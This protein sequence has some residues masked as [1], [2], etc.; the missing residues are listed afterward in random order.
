MDMPGEEASG[1]HDRVLGLIGDLMPHQYPTVDVPGTTFHLVG[2]PV[3]VPTVAAMNTLLPTW[4]DP[5]IPLGPFAEDAAETEVVRPRHVQ[6][7]PGYLAAMLVHRR[8]VTAKIAYQEMQGALQAR[9]E[10]IACRDVLT[11]LRAAATARGGGGAQTGV[12]IV[13]HPFTPLHLPAEVYQFVVN[14]L[15]GDLPALAAPDALTGEVT[16]TLAG[17]LRVLT[18]TRTRS[19]GGDRGTREAKTVQEAYKETF[20]ILLRYGNVAE[21]ADVAPIWQRLA[22]ASKKSEYH[23]ILSQELQCVCIARGL[24]TD[25]YVPVVTTSLKQMII[26][27]QF[28]GNGIDDLRSGCLP[29]Q[30]SYAGSANH[31]RAPC[32]SRGQ[33]QRSASSR[34]AQRELGRSLNHR[35]P[36]TDHQVSPQHDGGMHHGGPLLRIMPDTLLRR[37]GA[38]QPVCRSHVAARLLTPECHSIYHGAVH[39]SR[40]PPRH[41]KRLL[42][43]YLAER[44]GGR[45]RIPTHGRNKSPRSR[46]WPE[47]N[48]RSIEP[49]SWIS[50]EGH[51]PI[52]AS[53]SHSLKATWTHRHQQRDVA[54]AG[55]RVP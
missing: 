27:F 44:A 10:L 8:G 38:Q 32:T 37:G 40:A 19:D 20:K 25:V 26:G 30:V 41:R 18:E 48:C 46:A 54:E 6:L 34:R 24:A 53:G 29:F 9:G 17:A 28:V 1:F 50:R 51:S 43:L 35:G 49:S 12:P 5:L 4:E 7:V 22:N 45:V 3:R 2:M 23:T 33:C 39:A 15:R 16:G 14:K 11:W 55:A 42:R 13:Y 21:P 52:P 47:W 31:Y 36:R